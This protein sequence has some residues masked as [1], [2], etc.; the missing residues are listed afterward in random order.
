VC[1]H[2]VGHA[3]GRRWFLGSIRELRAHAKVGLLALTLALIGL[4][5]LALTSAQPAAA[6]GSAPTA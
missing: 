4:P 6:S 5:V 2:P 3:L 1:R